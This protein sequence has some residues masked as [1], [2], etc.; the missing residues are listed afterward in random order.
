MR[1]LA[2]AYSS[3]YS[4]DNLHFIHQ[5]EMGGCVYLVMEVSCV[6]GSNGWSVFM[7]RYKSH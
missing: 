5:Q 4:A 6:T 3:Y 2:L 1:F 7:W